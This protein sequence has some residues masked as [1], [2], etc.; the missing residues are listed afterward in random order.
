M[1]SADIERVVA[2]E[3]SW[4]PTPWSAQSF[5]NE[6]S[7]PFSRSLV[8]HAHG[9]PDV[10]AG[11][12]VR[13]RV[14]DEVHLLSLAVAESMR[15]RGLGSLMLDEIVQEGRAE[16]ARLVTLEVEAENETAVRLYKSRGFTEVR[17]R[18]SYYGAGRDGLV[19]N[20]ELGC[21]VVS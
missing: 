4:A 18:K 2:I 12:L 21:R 7:I 19:L 3:Q 6:L 15:R 16:S 20:L 13:W 1:E 5:R 10:V 9:T 8:A 11:Y 17:C 14:A